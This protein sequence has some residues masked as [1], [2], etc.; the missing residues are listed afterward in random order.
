MCLLRFL[1]PPQY[2][3]GEWN[4]VCGAHNFEKKYTA[5]IYYHESLP[6]VDLYY[7]YALYSFKPKNLR[8]KLL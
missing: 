5:L 1:P 3:G 7:L 8:R 6:H 2:N 4:F